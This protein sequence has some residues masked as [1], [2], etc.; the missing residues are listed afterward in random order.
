MANYRRDGD[1]IVYTHTVSL[2]DAL[3]MQP[4]SVNT[5]DNRK[6]FVSPTDV[7]TP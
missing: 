3:Q 4:V 7:V 1:N 5:L 2:L 6:V